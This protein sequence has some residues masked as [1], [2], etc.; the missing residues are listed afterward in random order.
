MKDLIKG[1][2]PGC[3]LMA[4]RLVVPGDRVRFEMPGADYT[5]EAVEFDDSNGR[6][7][8]R[9]ND[10]TA[11]SGYHPGELL[12]VERGPITEYYTDRANSGNAA[13]AK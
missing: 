9:F 3:R 12:W 4:A 13:L 2:P 6:V 8:H 7:T 10:D 11:S 1:I 5:V